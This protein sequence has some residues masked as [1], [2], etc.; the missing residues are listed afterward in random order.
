MNSLERVTAA[1]SGKSF[2]RRPVSIT[3]SLYGAR[4]TNCPLTTYY[5]DADEYFRGQEAVYK[6]FQPD[7][8]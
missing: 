2:D 3:L 6:T 8:L 4:L 1:L 7:I 5:T